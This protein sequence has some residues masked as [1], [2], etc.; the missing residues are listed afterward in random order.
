MLHVLVWWETHSNLNKSFIAAGRSGKHGLLKRKFGLKDYWTA[1]HWQGIYWRWDLMSEEWVSRSTVGYIF[2]LRWAWWCSVSS[3][4]KTLFN[5][6]LE[7]EM[8]LASPLSRWSQL[9]D[10]QTKSC[11]GETWTVVC[12]LECPLVLTQTPCFYTV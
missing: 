10:R 6:E 1:K 7:K 5:W 2:L 11:C 4:F 3:I 8:N 12:V 9:R